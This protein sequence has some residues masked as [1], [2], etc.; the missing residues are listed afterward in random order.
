MSRDAPCSEASAVRA[1]PY[2]RTMTDSGH[3]ELTIT[4]NALEILCIAAGEVDV[5]TAPRLE[6]EVRAALFSSPAPLVTLDVTDVSFM[7]SSGLGVIIGLLKTMRER[8]GRLVVRR[9]T[10]T[11]SKLLEVTDLTSTLDIEH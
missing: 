1:T 7:D 5:H 6:G 8:D 2:D 3:L 11:V 9:P 10:P 4:A